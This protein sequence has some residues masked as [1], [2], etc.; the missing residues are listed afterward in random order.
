MLDELTQEEIEFAYIN[1]AKRRLLDDTDLT[2]DA[3]DLM[4]KNG[5]IPQKLIDEFR[6]PKK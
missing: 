1:S 4:E 2:Q 6:N 5:M 3:V